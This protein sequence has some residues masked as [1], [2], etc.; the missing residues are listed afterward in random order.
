M[1]IGR[2]L[3]FD[4]EQTLE[5]VSEVFRERGF[6]GASLQDLLTATGLSKSSLYQQYGNKQA[7]FDECLLSYA[8]QLESDMRDGLAAASS[9]REFI[10][11]LLELIISEPQPPKGCL[12]FNTANEFGQLDEN[13]STRVRRVFLGFRAI[14]IEAIEQD[15]AAGLLPSGSA[16]DQA[17]FFMVAIAG[18]RT[19]VKGGMPRAELRRSCVHML[20]VLD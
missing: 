6:Q 17:N 16:Q 1:K 3:S 12:I 18:L 11:G 10:A 14:I 5:R 19:L 2:P 8:S 15:Q 9:G 13:V 7:L 20:K 4:R